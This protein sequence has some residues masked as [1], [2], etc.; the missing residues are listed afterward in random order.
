MTRS[1]ETRAEREA[2]ADAVVERFVALKMP[3]AP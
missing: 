1:G 2:A 3:T